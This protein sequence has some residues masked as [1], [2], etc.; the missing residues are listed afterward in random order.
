LDAR[1]RQTSTSSNRIV[2]EGS[3]GTTLAAI[4]AELDVN[5]IPTAQ[6]R[7]AL[8][9]GDRGCGVAIRCSECSGLT[10]P[11]SRAVRA[12]SWGDEMERAQ[13]G[14]NSRNAR[15]RERQEMPFGQL[16][17]FFCSTPCNYS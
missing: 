2:S 3:R 7:T 17:S 11:P 14:K 10:Q 12:A 6:R 9:S 13:P 15:E 5:G 4:A 1:A 16:L 8:V